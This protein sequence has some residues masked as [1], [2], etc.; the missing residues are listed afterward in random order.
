MHVIVQAGGRGSR[1]RHHTWNKPKCLVSV[2]GQP[3][4]HHIFDRFPQARF[5]VIG[6]YAFDVLSAYLA[7]NPPK[8]PFELIRA[9]GKGTLAGVSEALRGIAP[10][11]PVLI[12]WSDLLIGEPPALL[13]DE[14]RPVVGLT[15]SF[16]CRWSVTDAGALREVSSTT[17]GIPGVFY[18]PRRDLLPTPPAEGEFMRW[19]VDAVPDFATQTWAGLEEVGEFTTIESLNNGEGFTRFFNKV[20]IREHEVEKTASD[21][22]YAVLIEREVGW[23]KAARDLGFRRIPAVISERPF[24]MERIK[25]AH[26]YQMTDLTVREQRAVVADAIEALSDLH[27]LGEAPWSADDTREV[28]LKKTIAR[29]ESVRGLIP[30]IDKDSV[31]INGLKCRNPFSSRHEGLLQ[32]A[33]LNLT[34]STFRPIHGDPTFSNS[35][36]DRNLRSW[37][38]DPRGYFASSGIY[39]D[40]LY[41]F[42]K[43]Y[44]S[45]VG[46][47]DAFNRRQFKL[48]VDGD[49]V[50]ILA[51]QPALSASAQTVFGDYLRAHVHDIQV[52]HAFIWL[53]LSGYVRDDVDSVIASFFLGLY[54]LEQARG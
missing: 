26:A 19:F 6:D 36:V 50:E 27:R 52:I 24:V 9:A 49:T 32:D 29:V 5:T 14:T 40:P 53:S 54:W 45:A 8:T 41:D 51:E 15:D 13:E 4:L 1:L 48:H 20:A 17:R 42:A 39:G 7:Y 23:Y 38:I 34:P 43:V 21:P 2:R 10:E 12:V 28:Y 47:Y 11:E 16:V 44:Y 22:E 33:Y 25:G 18:L 35:L 31:T 46:G 3:V 37:F 30:M